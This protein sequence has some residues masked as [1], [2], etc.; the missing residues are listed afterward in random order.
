MA[1]RSDFAQKLLSD[2]RMRKERMGMAASQNSSR[3]TPVVGDAYGN[4]GRTYK[5]SR[6]IKSLES[7]GS[8]PASSGRRS[9]GGNRSLNN[10]ASSK[11]IVPFGGGRNSQQVG[12][13][14][15]ALAFALEH[16]GK[17]SKMD[18]SGNSSMLNFL[19]QIGR[20]SLDYGKMERNTFDK[21]R[22]SNSQF[23]TLS[24]LHIKEI[25]RGAQKLNHILKAC[26]NGMNFDRYS[27]EIGRELLKGA[28]DL[29]E[30]LRML[31]NL[32]DASEYMINPQ[33]KNRIRLL[34]EDGEEEDGT[35]RLL[36]QKQVDRPRF[37]FDKP[38]RNSNGIQEVAKTDL[39]QKLM[40]LAYPTEA[41]NV[42]GQ[43]ALTTS[44][45]GSHKRAA[46]PDFKALSAFLESKNNSSSSQYKP[47]KGRM[48]NV[49]AKLMGLEDLPKNG[50]SKT[51][52]ESNSKK[53]DQMLPKKTAHASAK[54]AEP[55][56]RGTKNPEFPTTE[57]SVQ[58]N[59]IPLTRDTTFV[60][61]A[62]KI[63][64]TRNANT[65]E[66]IPDGK[67]HRKDLE[68]ADKLN[69]VPGSRKATST[70]SKQQNNISQLHQTTVSRKEFQQEGGHDNTK[71]KEQKGTERG[72]T[73]QPVSKDEL[74]RKAPQ[75]HKTPEASNITQEKLE[76]RENTVQAEKKNAIRLIPISPQKPQDDQ[77]L[78]QLHTLRKSVAQEEKHQTEKSD[79]QS[80]KQKFLVRKPK[81][82]EVESKSSSRRVHDATSMQKQQPHMNQVAPTKRSSTEAVD[83]RPVKGLPNSRHQ[84]DRVRYG[85]NINLKVDTKSPMSGNSAQNA[86]PR[87]L[88]YETEKV[89]GSILAATEG[90]HVPVPTTQ[91]KVDFVKVNRSEA[92]R[93]KDEVRNRRNGASHNF[94]RPLKHQISS[95]QEMKQKRRDK[96]GFK[97][98]EQMSANRSIET[99]V[100]I[101]R[102]NKSE[103]S[104]Q[105]RNGAE[106]LRIEIEQAPT[107]YSSEGDECR[108]PKVPHTLNPNDSCRNRTS[109][110]ST[111][112]IDCQDQLPAFSKDQ[113]KKSH[114]TVP[115][116][117][118]GV[119]EGGIGIYDFSQNDHKK[120][121]KSEKQV[122]LTEWET[123]LKQILIKSQLF[124]N[125]AE[126]LFKLNIPIGILQ[127]SDYYS[128]DEESRIILDCCYEVMKRKGRRQELAI[129]PF[130][131]ISISSVKISS[132]DHLVKHLYKDLERS[133]FYGSNGSNEYDAADYLHKLLERDI[134]DRDPDVNSMWDFSWNEMMFTF[135]EKNDVIRDVERHV[136]NGLVDEIVKDLLNV[137]VSI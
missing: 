95:F 63:K 62:E 90:N 58:A 71:H 125:T 8:R 50:D 5:G 99:Q 104:I 130:V 116:P 133:R 105:S 135:H 16:G 73:K 33:R 12:D 120:V 123:D 45:L 30:S 98:A 75:K 11:Q 128:Q 88:G 46:S 76:N 40:A 66:L 24:H 106:Q 126:A 17:F 109:E 31:V 69:T 34:E 118:N 78:H 72:E 68:K 83:A 108:S 7:I 121:S 87:E 114:K 79:Q 22:P 29:E 27:I 39:R 94:A 67:S 101:I 23:P 57:K 82:S 3:S 124:L 115:S 32:Q 49:I 77:G 80:A 9:S 117:I 110:L 37:S 137:C 96:I 52:K 18:S 41:P 111:V 113:E 36:E 89:K 92:P 65:E 100:R 51:R 55:N 102:S 28:I 132:L 38:T 10:E 2:L 60:L 131:K 25:S 35:I 43:L 59:E 81:G 48:P 107:F 70:I 1:A 15:M 136:L 86:S 14:S 91:K 44:N 129:H 4:H 47:E 74:Q 21:H 93:K 13:L 97:G 103:A 19:H 127:G 56:T 54:N 119:N 42:P 20:R 6:Q 122:L 61:K 134:Q 53:Q 84:E 85:S 64:V 26:S 112:S